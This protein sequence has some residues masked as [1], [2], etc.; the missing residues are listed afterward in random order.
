MMHIT[1]LR[2]LHGDFPTHDYYPFNLEL[3]RATDQIEF[4][5]PVTFI[6]GENG[7]GKSTLLKAIARNC[8]I[9]LWEET[10]RMRFCHNP[11]ENELYRY[12]TVE[13]KGEKVPG[14]F[15]ASEIFRHFA[16]ILDEWAR[17]DPDMLKYFGDS[18]LVNKSHGQSHM[19]YFANRFRLPGLYLL[20]EPETALSPKMQLE[21]LK[22]LGTFVSMGHAQFIIATHS[23][24]LLAYPKADIFSFDGI[25][26]RKIA[27]ED[28]DYYRIYRDFLNSREK[29]LGPEV[30]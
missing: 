22:L 2:I 13:W 14:A 4:S 7:S 16:E 29:Y 3:F 30:G 12:I 19:A 20:D 24:I 27:Y 9:A 28:T 10:E 23:P 21:L 25:P 18:S 15:F 1:R 26:I 17:A 8:G 6:I 5:Q 11:Y